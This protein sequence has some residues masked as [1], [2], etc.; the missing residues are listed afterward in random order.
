MEP[1]DVLLFHCNT[2]HRS[3]QNR[4]PQR[5]WTII[6]CYNAARNNP[7]IEHHHPCYTPLEKV[8]DD[9]LMNAGLSFSAGNH[10]ES[11]LQ[12]STAPAELTQKVGTVFSTP[13]ERPDPHRGSDKQ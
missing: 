9:A 4:S 13:T 11:F 10:S 5:R 8:P 12:K 1:G 2:L 3:D 6:C 7:F